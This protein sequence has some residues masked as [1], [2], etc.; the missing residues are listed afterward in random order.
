MW[1]ASPP[2]FSLF[3]RYCGSSFDARTVLP[4]LQK[5]EGCEAG[6]PRDDGSRAVLE[7]A[8]VELITG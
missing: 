3:T 6:L 8:V 7:R 1:T 5:L 4:V 2:L